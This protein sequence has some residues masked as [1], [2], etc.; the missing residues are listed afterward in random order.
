M[1]ARDQIQ[2][3]D[4]F[5]VTDRTARCYYLFGT[6]G[7]NPWSGPAHGFDAYRSTDLEEW[8]GPFP[9][10]R[11][12]QGFWASENFW[13]PEVHQHGGRWYMLASFKAPG[14]A[15][16]TDVLVADTPLGPYAPLATLTPAH[17]ECLDGTLWIEDG[18]PWLVFCHEWLQTVDGHMCAVPLA[19]DL[20]RTVAEPV[21][22]FT[23][24]QA[25]WTRSFAR[26]GRI[27]NRVTDG[28]FLHRTP[29]GSLLM[30]WSSN[31]AHG[32]AMGQARSR[33]GRLAGPWEHLPEPLVGS[34]GGHG[35]LFSDLADRLML[36]W[37]QPNRTPEERPHW[38]PVRIADDRLVIA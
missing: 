8:K 28:P 34:D 12:P 29:V 1:P 16:A 20:A 33:S 6:T 22:L 38:R 14:V 32:Y 21:T 13:A 30:L 18:R 15:R 24:S 17:W 3:R 27:G 11:P 2:I 31:G 7:A 10:F 35:M 37:H 5:I 9:A 36:T 26:D 23:A 25:P 4:P 19:D